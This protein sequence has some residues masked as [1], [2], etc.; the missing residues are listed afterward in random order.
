MSQLMTDEC[1]RCDN[2]VGD[3]CGDD[4]DDD[5]DDDFDDDDDD[6]SQ[7][8]AKRL[9]GY[10]HF[11]SNKREWNNCFIENN[12]EILVDLADFALQEQPEDN[13]MVIISRAW[14]NGSYTMAAEPIKSLEW[15][16]TMIQFLIIMIMMVMILMM[17]IVP[18][19]MVRRS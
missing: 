19:V 12:L 7:R 10:N 18:L 14:H 1:D 17:L 13:L 11:T 3:D 15:H 5:D 9:V 8:G 2:S 4:D 6:Y 16:Y